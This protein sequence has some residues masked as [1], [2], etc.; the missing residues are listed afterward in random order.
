[1]S[2]LPRKRK[3]EP[4]PRLLTSSSDMPSSRAKIWVT[5]GHI[6]PTLATSGAQPGAALDGVV[7]RGGGDGR[8]DFAHDFCFGDVSQR[9]MTRA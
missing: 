4:S 8:V 9:Q 3:R 1:M 6:E 2:L 7:G 5:R